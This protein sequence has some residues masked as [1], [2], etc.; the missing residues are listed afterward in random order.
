MKEYLNL[1]V[2]ANFLDG[3][4]VKENIKRLVLHL[5]MLGLMTAILKPIIMLILSMLAKAGLISVINGMYVGG[6]LFVSAYVL[7]I[8]TV[9]IILM[10]ILLNIYRIHFQKKQENQN[11]PTKEQKKALDGI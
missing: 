3:D 5:V 9:P 4:S 8:G 2:W 11:E 1:K 10:I 6:W 7:F